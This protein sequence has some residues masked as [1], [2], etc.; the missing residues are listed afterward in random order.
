MV[1]SERN[2]CNSLFNTKDKNLILT[3]EQFDGEL[4][5]RVEELNWGDNSCLLDANICP[6]SD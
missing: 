2:G 3:E 4:R 6:V 1:A 5:V